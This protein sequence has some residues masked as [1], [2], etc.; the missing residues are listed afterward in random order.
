MV[1]NV[2]CRV[3]E[4]HSGK[5]DVNRNVLTLPTNELSKA[6]PH[7]GNAPLLNDRD[8]AQKKVNN[9][10]NRVSNLDFHVKVSHYVAM[11]AA[12]SRA[13]PMLE[14]WISAEIHASSRARH[15]GRNTQS[16]LDILLT[17]FLY[18]LEGGMR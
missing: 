15:P 10:L 12:R 8:V 2:N 9:Y 7:P 17:D 13:Q 6:K 14:R 3:A 1:R 11:V 4:E 16:R 5:C 18:P